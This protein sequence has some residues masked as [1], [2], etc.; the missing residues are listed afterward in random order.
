MQAEKARVIWKYLEDSE[1]GSGLG[2]ELPG[3]SHEAFMFD[4]SPTLLASGGE[5][6]SK[7]HTSAMKAVLITLDFI[8]KHPKEASGAKAWIVAESYELTRP[9]FE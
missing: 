4:P 6:G 8:A 5:R 9:E 2:Y 1:P 7:S 3:S